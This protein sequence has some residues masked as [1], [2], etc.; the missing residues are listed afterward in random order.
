MEHVI[1]FVLRSVHLSIEI[2]PLDASN[3]LS[4]TVEILITIKMDNKL[5]IV[6]NIKK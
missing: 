2:C 3:Y 5:K 6:L 4:N 1:C